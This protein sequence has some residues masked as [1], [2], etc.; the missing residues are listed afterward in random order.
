MPYINK[1]VR[2]AV[3]KNQYNIS[4]PPG[5]LNYKITKLLLDYIEDHGLSYETINSAMGILSCVSQELYRRVAVPYEEQKMRE[6][7]DVFKVKGE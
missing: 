6:N 7:G 3:Q 4:I 2:E 1:E 5:V